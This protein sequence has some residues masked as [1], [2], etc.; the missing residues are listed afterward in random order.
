ML[1]ICISKCTISFN[2]SQ[3]M[4]EIQVKITEQKGHELIHGSAQ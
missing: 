3:F 2:E 1:Q 4:R